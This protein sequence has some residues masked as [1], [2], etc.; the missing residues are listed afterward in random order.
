MKTTILLAPILFLSTAMA[1]GREA[2]PKAPNPD[3]FVLPAEK[4][5][6]DYRQSLKKPFTY[7]NEVP[8]WK[9]HGSMF[10]SSVRVILRELGRIGKKER[11]DILA[12]DTNTNSAT[13]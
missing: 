12:S 7:N 9:A 2:T 6:Y 8:F 13:V 5:R 1:W 4:R 10:S 11:E 3:D